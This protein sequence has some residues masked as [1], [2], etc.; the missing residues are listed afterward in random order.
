M[1]IL[2][3]HYVDIVTY[4]Y[5]ATKCPNILKKVNFKI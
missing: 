4:I 1:E 5:M 3:I 2:E